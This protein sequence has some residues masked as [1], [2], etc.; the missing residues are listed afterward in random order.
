MVTDEIKLKPGESTAITLKGSA[1]AGYL[2][3]YTTDDK[4]N[5]LE[6]TREFTRP[7]NANQQKAGASVDEVF[8]ITAQKKGMVN[9]HF[10]QQRSWEKNTEPVNKKKVN[11]II[12]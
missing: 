2:W 3:N 10:S 5:C 4:K 7:E 11:I 9:I 1:T 6:I 12:E 8:T